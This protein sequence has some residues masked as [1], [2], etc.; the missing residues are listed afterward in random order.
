MPREYSRRRP[1]GGD[2]SSG[3]GSENNPAGFGRRG[4]RFDPRARSA[5][6]F[7]D[8]RKMMCR[9]DTFMGLKRLLPSSQMIKSDSQKSVM[10]ATAGNQTFNPRTKSQNL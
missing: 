10:P 2:R 8:Q 3:K 4:C 9:L 7:R 6:G 5:K 1:A